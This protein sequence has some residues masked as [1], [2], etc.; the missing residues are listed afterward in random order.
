VSKGKPW[1]DIQPIVWQNLNGGLK[2]PEDHCNYKFLVHTEGYAYS[3][4]LK[5]LQMCRSVVVGHEMQYI[6]VNQPK[7]FPFFL[8]SFLSQFI[9]KKIQAN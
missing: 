5:Y 6:Q 3:G 8:A 4:R 7:I 9:K 1:S 2:T